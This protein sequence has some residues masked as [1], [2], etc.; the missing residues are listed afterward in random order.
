MISIYL[1]FVE[2]LISPGIV[3]FPSSSFRLVK[4]DSYLFA[5]NKEETPGNVEQGRSFQKTSQNLGTFK[6]EYV[7]GI[8]KYL[9]E[10]YLFILLVLIFQKV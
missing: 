6:T 2:K 3:T 4:P 1:S 5:R 10:G 9:L 7:F 8:L